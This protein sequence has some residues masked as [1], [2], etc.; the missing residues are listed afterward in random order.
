MTITRLTSVDESIISQLN[1]LLENPWD[2]DQA[3]QFLA[4]KDNILLLA[5]EGTQVIGF[6]TAHRLQRLDKRRAEVLLY[7][8]EVKEKFRQ[9]GVGKALIQTVK[10]WAKEVGAD[11]VWV[12]TYQSNDPAM[13]LY[14]SAG[15]IEDEPGTRMF[16]F[17]LQ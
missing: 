15:G 16:T 12:L 4:N 7:E 8:I 11:E 9:Q 17:M 14:Q 10:D 3:V 2:S 5:F 6:L 1:Q 13:K